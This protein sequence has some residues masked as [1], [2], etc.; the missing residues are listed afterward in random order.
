ISNHPDLFQIVTPDVDHFDFPL[1]AH[2]NC[3]LV[4]SVYQELR[5]GLWPFAHAHSPLI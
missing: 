3:P 1:R 5:E 2:L 4:A